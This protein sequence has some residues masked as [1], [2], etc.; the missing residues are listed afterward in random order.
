MN[1][2]QS[3]TPCSLILRGIL[4]DIIFSHLFLVPQESNCPTPG[5]IHYV[6]AWRCSPLLGLE[7]RFFGVDWICPHF[8]TILSLQA[9]P[10]LEREYKIYVNHFNIFC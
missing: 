6:F 8:F 2:V 7:L 1:I 5:G 4:P 10:C 3:L 9:S